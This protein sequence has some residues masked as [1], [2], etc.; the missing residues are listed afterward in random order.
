MDEYL[1]SLQQLGLDDYQVFNA[2]GNSFD[3]AAVA[4]RMRDA[5][6]AWLAG[7]EIPRR[8]YP[9]PTV[10][11][12]VYVGLRCSVQRTCATACPSP[13]PRG[14]HEA[15]LRAGREASS[16]VRMAAEDGRGGS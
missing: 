11:E 2:Q 4:L 15:V 3:R 6:T 1:G 14:V 7:I 5:V 9:P 16:S 8:E 10:V 13:F 12:Q